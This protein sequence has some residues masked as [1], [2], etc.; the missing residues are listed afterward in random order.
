MSFVGNAE[1]IIFE[2]GLVGF[3][4]I[5][6]PLFVRYF[7]ANKQQYDTLVKNI[8]WAPSCWLH[9]AL[10]LSILLVFEPLG[11][12]RI[13][14]YGNWVSGLKLSALIAF[15]ILQVFIAIYNAT[16]TECLWLA[17]VAALVSLALAIATTYLFFQ[18][19]VLAGVLMVVVC[20]VLFYITI[21]S[22]AVAVKTRA[23][24]FASRFAA[25]QATWAGQV[26]SEYHAGDSLPAVEQ[27]VRRRGAVSPS[28]NRIVQQAPQQQQQ[29]QQNFAPTRN[30]DRARPGADRKRIPI[31][32]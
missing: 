13:R 30:A 28:P 24:D 21:V 12:F 14:L 3:V 25:R 4:G 31:D 20:V 29:R 6:F 26:G 18:L 10:M 9:M 5:V 23:I 7:F 32:V 15:W 19:E 22:L 1:L 27:N 17:F 16:N 8:S 2:V 11:V